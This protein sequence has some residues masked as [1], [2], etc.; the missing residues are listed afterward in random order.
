M[1]KFND[2]HFWDGFAVGTKV[3]LRIIEPDEVRTLYFESYRKLLTKPKVGEWVLDYIIFQLKKE[4]IGNVHTR[5]PIDLSNIKEIISI[6]DKPYVEEDIKQN[7]EINQTVKT[8]ETLKTVEKVKDEVSSDLSDM[9]K[10]PVIEEKPE[11]VKKAKTEKKRKDYGF[12][13]TEKDG[14]FVCPCGSVF[15]RRD[16]A[17]YI[18]RTRHLKNTKN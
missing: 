1:K 14:K 18:H 8:I 4:E 3:V 15:G 9:Q 2:G 10:K 6:D 17:I 13:I 11:P 16:T 12:E 7:K 5:F